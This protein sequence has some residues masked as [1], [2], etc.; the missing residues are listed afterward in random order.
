[1]LF[2][3]ALNSKTLFSVAAL[4]KSLL[5][6]GHAGQV[7]VNLSPEHSNGTFCCI[8]FTGDD[9]IVANNSSFCLLFQ[10]PQEKN[11]GSKVPVQLR[12][13]IWLGLSALEKKFNSFAEGAF[14]V[15]AEMV[16]M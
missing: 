9:V 16:C 5:A 14:S 4:L 12:V 13:N 8:Y 6:Q 2:S 10:Y 11:S 3:Y 1:M 7:L 15:F